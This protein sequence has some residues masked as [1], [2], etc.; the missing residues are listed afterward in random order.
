MEMCFWLGEREGL[1]QDAG[2]FVGEAAWGVGGVGSG[3]WLEAGPGVQSCLY[4][5]VK[6][7]HSGDQAG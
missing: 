7:E 3:C 2:S 5:D 1:E 4:P 6:T